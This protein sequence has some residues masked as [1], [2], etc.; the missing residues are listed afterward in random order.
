MD[1]ASGAARGNARSGPR[2]VRLVALRGDGG[3]IFRLAFITPAGLTASLNEEF[4]RTTYSFRRISKTEA[5]AIKP[6]KIRVITV[7][8][9]DTADTLADAMPFEKYRRRWFA[10]LNRQRLEDGLQPGVKVKTVSE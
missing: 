3:R 9:G 8:K 4:R 10:T 6:L 7:A 1:G 5:A 2:D